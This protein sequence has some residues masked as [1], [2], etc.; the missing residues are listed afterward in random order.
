MKTLVA[1]VF[2]L[3]A[4]FSIASAQ[5][6]TAKAEADILKVMDDQAAA[7]NRGD[8]DAFMRGYWNSADLVFVSGDRITRGWQQTLDNYKK[9]YPSREQMGALK[10][11]DV[12][13]TV[14]SRNAAVVLGSWSLARAK[15]SPKGKFTLI[16]RK[17]IDGWRIV[18]DH[19]S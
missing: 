11:T 13:I 18:H 8:V 14:L 17:F 2:L 16:F 9:S 4:S 12:T 7:W 6:R 1:I 15:D 19:T 5:S 10:F 3:A